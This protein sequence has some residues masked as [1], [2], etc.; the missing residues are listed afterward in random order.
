MPLTRTTS[1]LLQT[2]VNAVSALNIDCSLGTYFTKTIA[3][4][5]TFT[6]SN[7]PSDRVY[8]LT[9]KLTVTSGSITWWTGVIWPSSITPTLT[10][11]KTHLLMFVTDNG[12]TVWRGSTITDYVS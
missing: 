1:T 3:A 9:L 12:G 11:G 8:A 4:N 10:A 5:T 7:V 6:V 2:N